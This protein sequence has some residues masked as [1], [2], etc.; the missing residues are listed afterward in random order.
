M[1]ETD[2]EE[3]PMNTTYD[4]RMADQEYVR[5]RSSEFE[6]PMTPVNIES[7]SGS[8]PSTPSKKGKKKRKRTKERSPR[9]RHWCFT[10][11]HKGFID[12]TRFL[13]KLRGKFPPSAILVLGRF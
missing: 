11:H 2:N 12:K 8:C 1:E 6:I 3:G 4:E 9:K 7:S 5:R 13:N 10:Y